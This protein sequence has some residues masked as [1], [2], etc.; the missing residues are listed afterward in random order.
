MKNEIAFAA[1]IIIAPAKD[2]SNSHAA[3]LQQQACDWPAFNANDFL[4]TC[5]STNPVGR[6]LPILQ[7]IA[8]GLTGSIHLPVS[9]DTSLEISLA[10]SKKP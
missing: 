10:A 1:S 8:K 3:K 5:Y 7:T 4:Q 2:E 9:A 6:I